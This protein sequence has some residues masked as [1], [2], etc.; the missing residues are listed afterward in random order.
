MTSQNLSFPLLALEIEIYII[1]S[2][3]SYRHSG[4][5][6]REEA[7]REGWGQVSVLIS[8]TSVS[9]I[10]L[11]VS[12]VRTPAGLYIKGNYLFPLYRAIRYTAS[13]LKVNS[14]IR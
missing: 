1:Y 14:M 6:L 9:V 4:H 10:L 8:L 3:C 7:P 2:T 5:I 11:Y 13:N 12:Y